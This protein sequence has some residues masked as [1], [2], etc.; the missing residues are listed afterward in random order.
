[1]HRGPPSFFAATPPPLSPV[2]AHFTYLIYPADA[3]GS[4]TQPVL[5]NSAHLTNLIF[6]IQPTTTPAA[7]TRPT[8]FLALTVTIPTG[9]G[10]LT[11][12]YRGRGAKMLSNHRFTAFVGSQDRAGRMRVTL[13]PRVGAKGV[14]VGDVRE[15]S[16]QL[17][18]VAVAAGA[19]RSVEV[20]VRER[21]AGK[22]KEEA[23]EASVEVQLEIAG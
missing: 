16:F 14:L 9:A 6:R 17:L 18:D 2:P 8:R 5:S 7:D 22:G 23:F 15:L 13:L 10:G 4:P 19:Q 11:L 1:M 21:Y 3:L 20:Q 12:A